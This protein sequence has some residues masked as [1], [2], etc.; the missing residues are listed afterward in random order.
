MKK[1]LALIFSFLSFNLFA[2]GVH[3][4][5]CRSYNHGTMIFTNTRLQEVIVKDRFGNE[6][7]I[8]SFDR[9]ESIILMTEPETL[10][11]TFSQ[12][13]TP[14][15]KVSKQADK[16]SAEFDGDASFQCMIPRS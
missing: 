2:Q 13:A 8:I 3:D 7:E 16:I 12:E 5:Q 14:F 4:Y 6:L 9:T 11:I 1:V 10:V 15:L